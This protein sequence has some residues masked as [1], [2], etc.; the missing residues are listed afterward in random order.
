MSH[1][2]FQEFCGHVKRIVGTNL[3]GCIALYHKH[4]RRTV[5]GLIKSVK[6]MIDILIFFLIII[7]LYAFL[8][9]LAIGDLN[10]E[11]HYDP[12]EL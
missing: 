5:V 9:C 7:V 11:Q 2:D 1:S 12:V 4:L 6:N 10:H 8:G 3:I